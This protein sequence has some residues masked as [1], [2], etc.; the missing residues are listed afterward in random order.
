MHCINFANY[1]IKAYFH[2]NG[3]TVTDQQAEQI[4][5]EIQQTDSPR[6]TLEKW[7]NTLHAPPRIKIRRGKAGCST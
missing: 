5:Q 1:L 6:F 7:L 4:I 3:Y 2:A